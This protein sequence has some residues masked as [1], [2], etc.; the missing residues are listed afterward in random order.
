MESFKD[1]K[2]GQVP[3]ELWLDIF[4]YLPRDTIETI[5][6]TSS[7]FRDVSRPFLFAHFDFH[8]YAVGKAGAIL[9]PPNI[10]IDEAL[11]RLE[12][13]TSDDIARHVRSCKIIAWQS[14]LWRKIG[15]AWSSCKFSVTDSPHTL[16]AP[17]FARL[18]KFTGLQ[19]FHAEE[20]HFTQ[21]AVASLCRASSLADF[22]L[23]RCTFAAGERID[24]PSLHL[25][26]SRFSYLHDEFSLKDGI[27]LWIPLLRLDTI[28]E[29]E[30]TCNPNIIGESMGSVPLFPLVHTLTITVGG[31]G[32]SYN[33][34][35]L[36]HFPAVEVFST[37][38]SPDSPVTVSTVLPVL[39]QYAGPCETIALF[40]PRSTL[41]H[42]AI[43]QC[44]PRVFIEQLNGNQGPSNMLSLRVAFNSEGFDTKA[45]RYIRSFFPELKELL[46][47][48]F[49][50]DRGP[51]ANNIPDPNNIHNM[52]AMSFIKLGE[53]FTLP[54]GLERM[55]FTWIIKYAVVRSSYRIE[56]PAFSDVH[57]ALVRRY[58][59][60][61]TVWL[62]GHNFLFC[63][64]KSLYGHFEG[65]CVATTRVDAQ[66]MR[67]GFIRFWSN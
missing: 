36:S 55:M 50:Y 56:V 22:R 14:P 53:P 13:Y 42:L 21:S 59:A 24:T 43:P 8:P 27:G 11:E 45:I 64:R 51:D 33:L 16:I 7:T 17:F 40:L 3:N 2:L 47:G 38:A 54:I 41:T 44:S 1:S 48:V 52:I 63:W 18:D 25:G 6:L 4:R 32:G 5:S 66:E 60:L 12:F 26:V 10:V 19:S 30:L 49:H 23:V 34:S 15:A 65:K 28:R 61:T 67:K 57:D 31:R 29:L 39:R 9:L 58:P 46:I 62:D 20:I 37:N 35:V